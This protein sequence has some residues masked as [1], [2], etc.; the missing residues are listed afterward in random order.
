MK[1]KC[2]KLKRDYSKNDKRRKNHTRKETRDGVV[3]KRWGRRKENV[4]REG[5]HIG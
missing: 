4:T 3:R 2:S 5:I 1:K